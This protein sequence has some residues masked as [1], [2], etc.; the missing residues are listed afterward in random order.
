MKTLSN[1]QSPVIIQDGVQRRCKID[2]V[3]QRDPVG[4]PVPEQ[5]KAYCQTFHKIDKGNGAEAKYDLG[6]NFKSHGWAP[7]LSYRFFNM[8]LNK[9][10]CFYKFCH[11]K[12][13]RGQRMMTM[14]EAMKEKT[15]SLLQR[16]V[17]MC[18]Y[19]VKH[20]PPI[21]NFTNA[22]DTHTRSFQ[23]DSKGGTISKTPTVRTDEAATRIDHRKR[24]LQMQK[25]KNPWYAHQPTPC[26]TKTLNIVLLN[27]VLV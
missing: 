24:F 9:S 23:T 5:R 19:D 22:Y 2:G 7:K 12:Y 17:K 1:F 4:V 16:D 21:R 6:G 8:G 13:N 10:Y 25:Q 20:P 15:Y 11:R 18:T 27:D 3:R 26:I 14:P